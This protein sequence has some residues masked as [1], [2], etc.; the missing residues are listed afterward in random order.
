MKFTDTLTE[1]TIILPLTASNKEDSMKEALNCLLNEN[2]LTST[3]KLFSLIEEHDKSLN[4]AVGRGTAIHYSSSVEIENPVSVFCISQ[5]G[6]D[7]NSPDAQKVHFIFLI[8][9]SINNPIE[10][11]KLITRFQHFINEVD[12]KSKILSGDSSHDIMQ[13]ILNW[14]EEYLFNEKI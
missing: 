11:R 13:I 10:H 1:K 7:Y 14:E 3:T 12:M 8:L 9:D 6:I 5:N 2:Y 4:S